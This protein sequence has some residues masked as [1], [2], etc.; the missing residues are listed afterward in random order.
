MKGATVASTAAQQHQGDDET[1]LS[2][3]TERANRRY[4]RLLWILP[5]M[6]VVIA[7]LVVLTAPWLDHRLGVHPRH[8]LPW[9]GKVLFVVGF[10]LVG[11]VEWLVIGLVRR[12]ITG[13]WLPEPAKVLGAD[14]PVRKRVGRALRTGR[15]PEDP[16]ERAL[17]L[18]QAQRIRSISRYVIPILVGGVAVQVP[19]LVLDPH[20]VV[21][22]GLATIA[23][24]CLISL[25]GWLYLRHRA[26]RLT[27]RGG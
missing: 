7:T 3:F 21:R 1:L 13:T 16:T 14:R 9:W 6:T 18:N 15:L 22:I 10:V 4:R 12:R 2:G 27:V 17:A 26:N 23:L 20:R 5:V 19:G 11:A 25:G 8:H 24:G